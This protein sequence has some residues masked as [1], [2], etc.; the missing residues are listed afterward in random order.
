ML[1]ERTEE[2]R[3][4]KARADALQELGRQ[5][6]SSPLAEQQAITAYRDLK[7]EIDE[8]HQQHKRAM[9]AEAGAWFESLFQN[10]LRKAHS[11]MKSPTQTSPKNPRWVSSVMDLRSE[12]DDH[13]ARLEKGSAHD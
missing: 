10:G 13:L 3:Q 7:S 4:F 12:I 1:A 5:A 8:R 9:L 6:N 11:A 2:L